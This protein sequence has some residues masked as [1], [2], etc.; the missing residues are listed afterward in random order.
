MRDY[1]QALSA[2]SLFFEV[3]LETLGHEQ[4]YMKEAPNEVFAAVVTCS[5]PH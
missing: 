3:N 1:R 5:T 4:V 2:L